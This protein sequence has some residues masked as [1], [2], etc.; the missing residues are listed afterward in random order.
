VGAMSLLVPVVESI[1]APHAVEAAS[2]VPNAQCEGG[3]IGVGL[4]CAGGG[5]CI[6]RGLGNCEC[7]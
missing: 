5:K 4:N 3:C 1:V 2:T 6:K 7:V